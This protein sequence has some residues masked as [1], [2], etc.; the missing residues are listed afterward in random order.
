MVHVLLIILGGGLGAILRYG[1]GILAVR[2][3]GASFPYGTL[4]VNLAGCLLIGIIFGL[5]ERTELIT[6]GMRLF[7]LTGFLGALTTFSSF[8][9]ESVL[10]GGGGLYGLAFLNFLINN[11]GGFLLVIAGLQV[12]S[13]ITR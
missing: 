7:L 2:V 5:G 13:L 10:A 11:I 4:I 12:A 3:W 9:L 8:A 6:P 1:V